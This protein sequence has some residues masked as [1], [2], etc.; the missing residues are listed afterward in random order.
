MPDPIAN[1]PINTTKKLAKAFN[2]IARSNWS[3]KALATYFSI[4]LRK[5]HVSMIRSVL[6][7]SILCNYLAKTKQTASFKTLS[8][9]IIA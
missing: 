3:F 5:R 9:K 4:E 2:I 7:R 1:D 6:N 8:P